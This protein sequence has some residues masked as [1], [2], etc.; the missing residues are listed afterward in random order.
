MARPR[1]SHQMR[2]IAITCRIPRYID[3]W[4]MSQ[5]ASTGRVI[6]EALINYYDLKCDDTKEQKPDDLIRH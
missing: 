5:R 6:E 2:R 4:L 3:D 1:V